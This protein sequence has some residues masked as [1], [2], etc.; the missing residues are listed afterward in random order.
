MYNLDAST[1]IDLW[2]NYP[3]QNP[4]FEG[5]WDKFSD[6]VEAEIFVISDVAI[7][8]VR[9]KILYDNIE[10]EIPKSAH[11]KNILDVIRVIEKEPVDL[12]MAQSIKDL[13]EIEEDN[14]GDGVGENDI[15][16]VA[17]TQ[18]TKTILVTN[19]NRQPD[20]P[21]NKKKYKIPAVCNLLDVN[22]TNINLTE[23][24]H[25]PNLW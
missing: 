1:L 9:D 13:L 5:L 2:D 24:L 3:I 18:R 12:T 8:E 20:L 22:V 17:I 14:Y 23:L 6:N 15:L 16:I 19:E 25:K 10:Q 4:V 7:K 21:Q 11:F